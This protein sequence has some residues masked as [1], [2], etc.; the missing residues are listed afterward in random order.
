ML[1]SFM[2]WNWL[3]M[4]PRRAD[5][6]IRG[7]VEP[8]RCEQELRKRILH[9]GD[10]GL[11]CALQVDLARHDDVIV[12]RAEWYDEP[13]QLIQRQA[14]RG[15]GHPDEAERWSRVGRVA[16]GTLHIERSALIGS[17]GLDRSHVRLI[18]V[19]GLPPLSKSRLGLTPKKFG[20]KWIW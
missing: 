10:A 4:G 9:E 7:N 20:Q 11:W 6:H 14:V 1:A 15:G 8:G 13:P 5:K 18:A 3:R 16:V 17:F 12:R 19:R 2:Y